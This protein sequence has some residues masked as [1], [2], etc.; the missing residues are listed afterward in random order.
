MFLDTEITDADIARYSLI[1]IGGPDANRVSA[2]LASKLPL[3][4]SADA[5]RIDGQEFKARDAAVQMIYP[6]P[7]NAER[8]V[9]IFAGTST[10]GMYF[11][12]PNPCGCCEWDY[13]V[14]RRARCRH[15]NKPRRPKT[16]RGVGHVRLQLAL[17]RARCRF[18]AMPRL[19]RRAV[20]SSGL[21][22]NLKID[23]KVL[24]S[25]VGRYQIVGGPMVEVILEG[26]KLMALA[27]RPT[28]MIPE[29]E[30]VFFSPSFN[31]RV[32]FSRDDTGKVTG[33]TTSGNGDFEGKKLE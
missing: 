4:I 18:R 1:L 31:A 12:E 30:D 16:A 8:Y 23:P 5:V 28:E 17:S 27:G 26:G 32:F 33:F 22:Q 29:S 7:L 25:Y 15:S 20:N 14:R 24:A 6:N 13:V 2:K 9:W 10:G 21:I 19:A 11:T 3:R